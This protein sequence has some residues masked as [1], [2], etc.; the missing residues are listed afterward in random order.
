VTPLVRFAP[1]PTGRIHIGNS[2]TAILNWLFARKSAGWFVLRYDDTDL[3]RCRELQVAAHLIKPV[4]QAQLRQAVAAALG[5]RPDAGARPAGPAGV[6]AAAGDVARLRV[7]VAE[8]NAVNQKLARAMLTRLGHTS[9]LASDGREAIAE[10]GTGGYDVVFM[11]VQMPNLDGFD[12]TREIRRCEAQGGAART[13]IAMFTANALDEHRALAAAA[14]ADFHIPKPITPESLL[15]GIE[16]ALA[17]DAGS[18]QSA[19]TG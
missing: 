5:Q 12:A 18:A 15:A 7:L 10:W 9:V 8:D 3:E 17:A 13:P 16:L 11:D 6:A 1:S 14:G 19:A 4:R 2:R